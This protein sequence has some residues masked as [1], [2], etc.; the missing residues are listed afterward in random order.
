ML[1]KH[2]AC[3]QNMAS[4]ELIRGIRGIHGIPGIPGICGIP[5]IP[6]SG[7]KKCCSDLSFHARLLVGMTGV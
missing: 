2:H 4:L 1:L 7:V 6:G 5:G 3:A